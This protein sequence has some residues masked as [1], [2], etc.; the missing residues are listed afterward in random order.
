MNDLVLLALIFGILFFIGISFILI[1]GVWKAYQ[2]SNLTFTERMRKF[3][4]N[5]S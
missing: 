5:E 1:I 4:E 2:H 3:F